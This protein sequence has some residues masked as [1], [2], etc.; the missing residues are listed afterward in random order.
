MPTFVV[1]KAT[2]QYL[3]PTLDENTTIDPP[4]YL[5][6][7]I[8]NQTLV[9]VYCKATELSTELQRYNKFEITETI[10]PVALN[11]EVELSLGD[12]TYKIYEDASSTN[13]DPTGLTLVETGIIKCSEA[14]PTEDTEYELT[15]T[16]TEYEP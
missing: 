5:W 2:S 3:Y 16:N 1:N 4:Y 12:H 14:N 6:E 11:G 13:L 8:N 9:K 15:V 10:S 7:I